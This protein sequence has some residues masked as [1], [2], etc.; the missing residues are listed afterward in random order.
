M[1]FRKKNRISIEGL[2]ARKITIYLF[3][4]MLHLN[5]SQKFTNKENAKNQISPFLYSENIMIHCT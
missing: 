4:K 3:P 5:I 1:L 2:L